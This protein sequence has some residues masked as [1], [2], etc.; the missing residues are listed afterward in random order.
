MI[1]NRILILFLFSAWNC[2]ANEEACNTDNHV[3]QM[4]CLDQEILKQQRIRE[5]WVTKLEKQVEIIQNNTGN[6][7]LFLSFQRSKNSFDTYVSDVC[8]WRY[9]NQLPD[10]KNAALVYKRCE[11]LV[12]KQQ[13][14]LLKLGF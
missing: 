8:Q 3:K 1:N 13:I 7:Q 6:T 9:L 4:Q 5:T 14:A 12:T 11:L 10:T 2:F